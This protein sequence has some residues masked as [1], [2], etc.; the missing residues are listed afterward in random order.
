MLAELAEDIIDQKVIF[1]QP[2]TCEGCLYLKNGE[3]TLCS[4]WC[5]NSIYRPYWEPEM[6]QQKEEHGED[7]K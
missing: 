2:R 6:L 5:V 7:I 4:G 1:M 3:C